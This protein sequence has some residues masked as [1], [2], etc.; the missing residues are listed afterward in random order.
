M[1]FDQGVGEGDRLA[2]EL[3]EGPALVLED[4][5]VLVGMF[6]GLHQQEAEIRR[7]VHI[8]RLPHAEH[9][10]L[11]DIENLFRFGDLARD[12][13]QLRAR[14]RLFALCHD[15]LSRDSLT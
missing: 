1:A 8:G 15:Q 6:H 10:G 5:A 12:R 14:R 3:T 11:A 4:H 7:C 2:D 13:L 9:L